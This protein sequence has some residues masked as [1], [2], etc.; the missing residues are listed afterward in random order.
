VSSK[1][2]GSGLKGVRRAGGDL[3]GQSDGQSPFLKGAE[4]DR[5]KGDNFMKGQEKYGPKTKKEE[6]ICLEKYTQ[7]V[8]EAQFELC[9]T[10]D[11]GVLASS[12]R[13][14]S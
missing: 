6:K 7:A 4:W 1:T 10:V 5:K 14:A 2:Q 11:N 8:T 13:E 3:G 12:C 9:L